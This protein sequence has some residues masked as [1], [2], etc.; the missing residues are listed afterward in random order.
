MALFLPSKIFPQTSHLFGGAGAFPPFALP[1]V[2][3]VFGGGVSV[4]SVLT[5][6]SLVLACGGGGGPNGPAESLLEAGEMLFKL[7]SLTGVDGNDLIPSIEWS[8]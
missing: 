7:G 3:G 8:L 2:S 5:V 4:T 6:T 1:L